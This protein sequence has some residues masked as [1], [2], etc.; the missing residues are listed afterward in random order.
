[1]LAEEQA[2]FRPGRSTLEQ[3]FN[4]RVIIEKHLQHQCDLFNNFIDFKKSCDRVWPIGLWQ[5]LRSL[6]IYGLVQAIQALREN[7]SSSVLLNSQLEE[8]FKT[9][10]G[11][12]QGCLLSPILCKLFLE[13][14]TQETLSDHHTSISSGV[15]PICNLRFA[16]NINFM[17]GSN[18]EL[19]DLTNRL[20][21]RAKAYGM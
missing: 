15:R 8:F 17:G 16:N 14:I 12:Y 1:M 9:T 11:V 20:V 7:S 5:A 19:Q 6:S 18:G 21:D 13:K 10:V 2:G 3:I 4:S